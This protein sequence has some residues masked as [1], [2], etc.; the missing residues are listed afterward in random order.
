VARI[1]DKVAN[2]ARRSTCALP[3]VRMTS[4]PAILRHFYRANT[5]APSAM[6]S[7]SKDTLAVGH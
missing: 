5:A 2:R 6:V 1:V 4:R 7:M 3:I